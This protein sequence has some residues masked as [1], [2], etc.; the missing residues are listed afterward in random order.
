[1]TRTNLL[2]AE[3]ASSLHL[4]QTSR[5]PARACCGVCAPQLDPASSI[6]SAGAL[7]APT[8]TTR[9][10]REDAQVDLF[11]PLNEPPPGR[12]KGSAKN[13]RTDRSLMVPRSAQTTWPVNTDAAPGSALREDG[14]GHAVAA[15]ATISKKNRRQPQTHHLNR[16]RRWLVFS[17]R[18]AIHS[19]PTKEAL[20]HVQPSECPEVMTVRFA[21]GAGGRW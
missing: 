12:A 15:A 10:T 20:R 17:I 18:R 7:A 8:L 6:P 3:R 2:K 14:G 21:P 19:T 1:M 9:R 11:Q 13:S 5:Q 16:P 4:R